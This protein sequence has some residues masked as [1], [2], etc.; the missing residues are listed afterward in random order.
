MPAAGKT[1]LARSLATHLGLPLIAK[2][3]IKEALYDTLGVGDL[4]WS[5]RLGAATYGLLFGFCRE[6]LSAGQPVIAEANFA[7]SQEPEFAA[8]PPHRSVQVHCAA[9]FEVL[10]ERYTKRARHPGHLD[11]DRTDDLEQRFLQGTHRPLKLP[12]A[13]IEVDSSREVDMEAVASRVHALR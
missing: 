3:D 4:E 6:L 7:G 1:T 11:I 5:R 2:D 8:L 10:V 12:G 13:V 9:P